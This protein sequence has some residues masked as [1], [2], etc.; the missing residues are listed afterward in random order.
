MH[1]HQRD[2]ESS[3]E[4]P[5]NNPI[6]SKQV[7]LDIPSSELLETGKAADSINFVS[8][9]ARTRWFLVYTMVRNPVVNITYII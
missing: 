8:K 6:D 1:K 5:G 7:A 2:I 4:L 9:R 3:S